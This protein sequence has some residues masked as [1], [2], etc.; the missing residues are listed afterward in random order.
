M[1]WIRSL[2]A[3]FGLAHLLRFIFEPPN[4]PACT[5][6][7]CLLGT[8]ATSHPDRLD[9]GSSHDLHG[10]ELEAEPQTRRP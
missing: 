4:A 5:C 10:G 1:I 6:G 7:E 3:V 9:P 2:P 8:V